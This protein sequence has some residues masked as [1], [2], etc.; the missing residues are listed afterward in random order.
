MISAF[1][2]SK[3]SNRFMDLCMYLCMYVCMY[4]FDYIDFGSVERTGHQQLYLLQSLLYAVII[5]CMSDN[6]IYCIALRKAGTYYYKPYWRNVNWYV[7]VKTFCSQ[8]NLLGLGLCFCGCGY[9]W[10]LPTV[11]LLHYNSWPQLRAV[12]LCVGR[13]CGSGK[14]RRTEGQQTDKQVWR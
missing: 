5:C 4:V 3:I 9:L 7:R 13:N 11:C 6:H 8:S 2:G 14:M 12:G 1:F 10:Q